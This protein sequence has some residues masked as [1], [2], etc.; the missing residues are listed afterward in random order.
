MYGNL[1]FQNTVP[2]PSTNTLSP[3]A[4]SA[5]CN[6]SA[7]FRLET[8]PLQHR[9]VALSP[10]RG[11]G[12]SGALGKFLALSPSKLH[13]CCSDWGP[14]GSQQERWGCQELVLV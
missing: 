13:G 2:F 11:L 6:H 14:C 9:R 5:I 3:K 7:S 8:L 4:Q 10:G 12:R 1:A